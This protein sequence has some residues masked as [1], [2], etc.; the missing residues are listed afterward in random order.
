ML[1]VDEQMANKDQHVG[2]V[3]MMNKVQEGHVQ[4]ENGEH[5]ISNKLKIKQKKVKEF[6][7]QM[8]PKGLRQLI[9]NLNDNQ[10]K[11]SK[12]SVAVWLVWNFDTCSCSLPFANDRMSVIEHDVHVMLG[13]PIGPLE[14]V[15]SENEINATVEFRSFLNHWKQQCPEHDNIP[16]YGELIKM[17]HG[18]VDGGED[19]RRNFV[20][21]V[22][23]TCLCRKQS[24][25][26]TYM[27]CCLD[28][29]VFKLRS[30]PR[31]LPTLR[32][33]TNDE[34]KY[35]ARLEAVTGFRRGYL[36]DTSDKTSITDE[37]E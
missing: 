9:E 17:I 32:G 12:K 33:L 22:V 4:S 24:G 31:Q 20:I 27:L 35:R 3:E 15:E 1:G 8:S 28:C 29:V 7:N 19:F 26:F 37:E 13:L 23:S 14:V 2:D 18:Q 6:I 11:A 36:E 34:I 5:E 21:F 30:V 25:E 16:K 10:K